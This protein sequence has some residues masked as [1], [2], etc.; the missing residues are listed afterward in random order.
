MPIT[1]DAIYDRSLKNP[2]LFW[3]HAAEAVHWHKRWDKVFDD[4]EAPFCKWFSGGLI[5][6]CYNALDL[7]VENGRANQLALIYD[8]PVTGTIKTYSYRALLDEVARFAGALV[9]CDIGRG[10]AVII[11]MPMVPETVI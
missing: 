11:Y 1:Y 3:E 9:E 5:N 4:S 10:D 2:E 8:S 7:H 6:T